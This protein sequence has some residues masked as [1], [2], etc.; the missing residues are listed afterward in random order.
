MST[1][2]RQKAKNLFWERFFKAGDQCSFWKNYWKC[3]KE[4][5]YLT[6][7]NRKEKK[8]F[9]IKTKFSDYMFSFFTENLLAI[10]M[11]KTQIL[12]TKP[13]N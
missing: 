2:I 9:S 4:Q 6:C 12:M 11:R 5:K 3:E 1:K 13:V 8:L 10:E 7:N